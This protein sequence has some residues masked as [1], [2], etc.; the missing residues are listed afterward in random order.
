MHLVSTRG[1]PL[2]VAV[3]SMFRSSAEQQWWRIRSWFECELQWLLGQTILVA[4]ASR[5]QECTVCV[6]VLLTCTK[7]YEISRG[8]LVAPNIGNHMEGTRPPLEISLIF[9]HHHR[10][11]SNQDA[12]SL[13]F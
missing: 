11:Q 4:G 6:P 12:A 8:G 13:L 10:N 2:G 5:P 1:N 3:E 7:T 9:L